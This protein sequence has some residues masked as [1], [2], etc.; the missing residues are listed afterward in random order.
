MDKPSYCFYLTEIRP[1]TLPMCSYGLKYEQN[2]NKNKNKK[3]AHNLH[4]YE[5]INKSV[6]IGLF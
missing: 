3:P 4:I 5:L 1:E 6:A 2:K